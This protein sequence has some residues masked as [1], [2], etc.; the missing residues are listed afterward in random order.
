[1]DF[2]FLKMIFFAKFNKKSTIFLKLRKKFQ[3]F[4]QEY[5]KNISPK[6]FTKVITKA[7]MCGSCCPICT[8]LLNICHI[9][10]RSPIL[11]MT[12]LYLKVEHLY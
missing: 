7:G 6:A 3:R 9:N 2:N 12:I 5:S 1:M 11:L 4:F 10:L 8:W